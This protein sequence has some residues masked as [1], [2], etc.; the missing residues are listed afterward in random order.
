MSTPNVFISLLVKQKAAVLPLFLET[1][2]AYDYPKDN[3]F[4]YI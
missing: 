1:L 4:L 2:E 3:M